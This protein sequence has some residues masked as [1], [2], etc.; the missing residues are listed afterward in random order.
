MT[1]FRYCTCVAT[2]PALCPIHNLTVGP[3]MRLDGTVIPSAA[4]PSHAALIAE[5][6]ALR[7]EVAKLTAERDTATCHYCGRIG[8]APRGQPLLARIASLEKVVEAARILEHYDS[9]PSDCDRVE[10]ALRLAIAEL[11]QLGTKEK[12]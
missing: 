4:S 2:E 6:A 9:S 10:E 8:A 7:A 12:L 1:E 3:D 11:A 5:I